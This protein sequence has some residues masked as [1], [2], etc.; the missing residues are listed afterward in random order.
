LGLTAKPAPGTA[1]HPTWART[2]L[3]LGA[4]GARVGAETLQRGQV[5]RRA[6]EVHESSVLTVARRCHLGPAGGQQ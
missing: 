2:S 6:Q 3:S 1:G 4:S 5:C